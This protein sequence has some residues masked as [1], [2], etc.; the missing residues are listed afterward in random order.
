MKLL[1]ENWRHY[2]SEQERQYYGSAGAGVLVVS[3]NGKILVAKRS[4]EVEQPGTWS[5]IGGKIEEGEG[6]R[7]AAEVEFREETAYLGPLTLLD[8]FIFRDKRF[9]YHNFIGIVAE[10]F[11]PVKNFETQEFRWLTLEQ[12][13]KLQP[14]HFGLKS[15]LSDKKS[16][17]T[18]QRA[19][20]G[21]FSIDPENPGIF[22]REREPAQVE[23]RL[24]YHITGKENAD[25]IMKQ[26]IYGASRPKWFDEN[27]QFEYRVYFW[28][29]E[30]AVKMHAFGPDMVELID[31]ARES[32][33]VVII[34]F[35]RPTGV[36]FYRDLEMEGIEFGQEH[37]FYGAKTQE[38]KT[39]RPV[40]Q[41]TFED[42]K[43]EE[44]E[45]D[46]DE[47]DMDGS[48]YDD[49]DYGYDQFSRFTNY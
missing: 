18:L 31:G 8:A 23:T 2:L 42:I 15:L 14:M 44:Y 30:N 4:E 33:D 45:D 1:F 46:V 16:I 11:A 3:P 19:I 26:G 48:E 27:G 22:M 9:V 12:V 41:I 32:E 13:M 20:N 35:P 49:N 34:V 38:W 5:N 24:L 25:S 39:G 47:D 7:E 40:Q 10:E 28:D 17:E 36:K 37:A 21:Q 6:A 29:N 43:S